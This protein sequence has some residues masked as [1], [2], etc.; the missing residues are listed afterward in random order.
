MRVD[1]V[2]AEL[3]VIPQIMANPVFKDAMGE[4]LRQRHP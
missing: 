4:L 3:P 1:K 2:T